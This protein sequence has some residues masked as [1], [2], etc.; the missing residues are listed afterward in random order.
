MSVNNKLQ[1]VLDRLQNDN[2]DLI[3]SIDLS[4]CNLH[5][6]P[7]ELFALENSLEI[8]NLGT[9]SSVSN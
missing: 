1:I 9:T 3:T 7:R 5:E 4:G 8:L 6:F 2:K